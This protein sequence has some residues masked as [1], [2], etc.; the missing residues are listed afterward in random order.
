MRLIGSG[1]ARKGLLVLLSSPNPAQLTYFCA[2]GARNPGRVDV[3]ADFAIV[4]GC[5]NGDCAFSR[6][7]RHLR[8]L[9][10]YSGCDRLPI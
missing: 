4:T 2:L 8:L 9:V 10:E 6:Y 1:E 3:A 7:I 5:T